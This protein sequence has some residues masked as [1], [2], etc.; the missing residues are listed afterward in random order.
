[1]AN[2]LARVMMD[3]MSR[4]NG[5]IKTSYTAE[6]LGKVS[7]LDSKEE[8]ILSRVIHKNQIIREGTKEKRTS[9]YQGKKVELQDLVRNTSAKEHNSEKKASQADN[10]K[11]NVAVTNEIHKVKNP[12]NKTEVRSSVIANPGKGVSAVSLQSLG[13]GNL[14]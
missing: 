2:P 3:Q 10:K 7:N 8:A 4:K 11:N 6:S 13:K 5:K 1:M 9:D 12:Y 14:L